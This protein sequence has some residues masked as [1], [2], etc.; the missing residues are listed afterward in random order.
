[1]TLKMTCYF[2]ITAEIL[3]ELLDMLFVG[4]ISDQNVFFIVA[5]IIWFF[6]YAFRLLLINCVCEK[7]S[8][9]VSIMFIF[10]ILPI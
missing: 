2:I 5:D 8:A 10:R 4:N 6:L 7:V 3:H 9:K 1:M